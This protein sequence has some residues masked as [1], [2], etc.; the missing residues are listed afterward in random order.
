MLELLKSLIQTNTWQSKNRGVILDFYRKYISPEYG[1]EYQAEFEEYCQNI[2]RFLFLVLAHFTFWSVLLSWPVDYYSYGSNPKFLWYMNFWRT[3][4]LLISLVMLL[5]HY[6]TNLTD[7]YWQHIFF[8][9]L[10]GI[11][12]TMFYALSQLGGLSHPWFYS[13]YSLP[14]VFAFFMNLRLKRRILFTLSIPTVATIAYFGTNP[15]HLEYPYLA[16][17]ILILSSVC[18]MSIFIGQIFHNIFKRSFIQTRRLEDSLQ[19]KQTLLEEVHHRVK[20]NL[21]TIRSLLKLQS[22]KVNSERVE[23]LLQSSMKRVSSMAQIHEQLYKTGNLSE[24]NFADYVI[25]LCE[26]QKELSS[27]G[28]DVE[29]EQDIDEIEM[30]LDQAITCGLLINELISNS[31]EHGYDAGETG[32]INIAMHEYADGK[33]RLEL[34]DDGKGPNKESNLE[35]EDTTGMTIVNSLINYGLEGEIEFKSDNGLTVQA[36]FELD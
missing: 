34:S 5:L 22:R 2:G 11:T 13:S 26:N 3:I 12:Y 16:T 10:L 35:S 8:V 7:H 1:V 17:P 33:I 23:K 36:E 30:N 31:L 25:R 18:F 6:T 20:N 9:A 19:E 21:Q 4:T 27:I 29:F 15:E 32:K 14:C 28:A 24:L